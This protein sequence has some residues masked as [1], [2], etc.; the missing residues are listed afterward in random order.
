M[1]VK[2]SIDAAASIREQNR[3][4]VQDYMSR[5]GQSRLTR[6]QLFTE[7]GIGGLWTTDTGTPVACQ[8]HQKIREHGEWS[9]K[10]FPDWKWI[11]VKIFDTQDP[12]HFWVE[13]D[14]EGQI[15]FADYPSG[16]YRNHFIF[17]FEFC[18]GRIRLQREFMNP[19]EQLRALG[20]PVPE[21]KRS[22]IPG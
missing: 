6:Y 16:F 13:C 8:G 21:I 17:S 4:V 11:N 19:F 18:N 22:G 7:D 3:R 10:T 2:Q 1:H 12:E 5:V 14:G 9:L 15:N 20:I